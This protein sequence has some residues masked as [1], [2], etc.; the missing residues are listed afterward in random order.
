M[1]I[2]GLTFIKQ[3]CAIIRCLRAVCDSWTSFVEFSWDEEVTNYTKFKKRKVLVDVLD[4]EGGESSVQRETDDSSLSLTKRCMRKDVYT[5]RQHQTTRL[6]FECAMECLLSLKS[7]LLNLH[8]KKLFP[9]NP[10][11]LLRRYV[12]IF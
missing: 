11:V 5:S 1:T 3:F 8:R 9:Y 4:L 6:P 12:N 10:D 7:S 2:L